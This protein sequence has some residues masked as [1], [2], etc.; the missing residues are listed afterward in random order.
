MWIWGTAYLWMRKFDH[1]GCMMNL[2]KV[3]KRI[4]CITE[5][6]H[7]L[8]PHVGKAKMCLR[9]RVFFLISKI[10]LHFSAVCLQ[11]FKINY[12][13]SN[14]FGFIIK[15]SNMHP[16]SARV[17]LFCLFS[18]GNNLFVSEKWVMPEA[19]TWLI[20]NFNNSLYL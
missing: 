9:G 12:R 14:A 6:V 19:E 1:K 15:G 8:L 11:F 4:G 13:I 5:M 10:Y 3:C 2:S 18:N 7:I 16:F 17:I 20:K